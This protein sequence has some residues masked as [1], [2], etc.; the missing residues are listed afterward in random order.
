M[1]STASASI[2]P[3]G[4]RFQS[5]TV[6]SYCARHFERSYL[7]PNPC[8]TGKFLLTSLRS[9]KEV[10]PV[11]SEAALSGLF[12]AQRVLFPASLLPKADCS[13][14]RQSFR[15]H[16]RNQPSSKK[17]FR[18]GEMAFGFPDEANDFSSPGPIGCR[19]QQ[20]HHQ[21]ILSTSE[22]WI[23]CTISQSLCHR[24][25]SQPL[26]RLSSF[27]PSETPLFDGG[28]DYSLIVYS[29]NRTSAQR[30]EDI[31]ILLILFLMPKVLGGHRGI[32]N[33]KHLNEFILYRRF[34]MQSL[35][36]ILASVCHNDLLQL[37]NL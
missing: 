30:P 14:D 36:S 2:R 26:L 7:A 32:L 22:G 8:F 6:S 16:G 27:P 33:L 23:Q 10:C 20:F 31:G 5:K 37:V 35:R 3:P 12:Q 18:G 34:Q 13:T 29:S 21:W 11:Q 28:R 24:L 4:S 17:P 9:G 15:D 1:A 19:L 25:P